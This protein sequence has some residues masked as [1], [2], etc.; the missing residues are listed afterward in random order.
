MKKQELINILVKDLEIVSC[1]LNEET[2]LKDLPEFTSIAVLGLI[3]IADMYFSKKLQ[4]DDIR[5]VTTV[6][7]YLELIGFDH[8][9]DYK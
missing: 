7:S 2:N 6:K 8:L 4:I 5:N 9:E 3:A 1:D